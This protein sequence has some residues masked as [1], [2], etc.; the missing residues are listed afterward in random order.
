MGLEGYIKVNL[1]RDEASYL[2]GCGEGCWAIATEEVKQL[3]DQDATGS[4]YTVIL[5][6][7]SIYY[8]E[9]KSGTEIPIELRGPNRAVV[10]LKWLVEHYGE[11]EW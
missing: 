8:P 10:P 11:A 1:P 2:D 6:N 5:D 7:D 3:Y 9:L 4:G